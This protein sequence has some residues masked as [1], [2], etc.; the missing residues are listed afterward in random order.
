MLSREGMGRVN[1]GKEGWGRGGVG[2]AHESE[3]GERCP[4]AAAACDP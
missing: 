2:T 3:E 1:G 4:T